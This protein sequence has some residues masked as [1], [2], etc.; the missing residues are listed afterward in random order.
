MTVELVSDIVNRM[1][2]LAA[3]ISA[4]MLG[5]GIFIGLIVAVLMAATQVQEA[6]LNFVPKTVA[7]GFML[8][9]MGPWMLDHI[10]TFTQMMFTE[11][12][13]LSPGAIK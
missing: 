6:A 5:V 7:I 13:F 8:M 1:L 3:V 2:T 11:L 4:P 12:I 10:I 9:W